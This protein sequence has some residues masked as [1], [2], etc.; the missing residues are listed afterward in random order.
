MLSS[1]GTGLGYQVSL[2]VLASQLALAISTAAE[3]ETSQKRSSMVEEVVVTAQKREQSTV[4][5]PMSI[6]AMGAGELE[7]KGIQDVMDLSFAVPGLMIREEGPGRQSMYMRGIGNNNG[8]G[9]LTSVYLDEAPINTG[10]GALGASNMLNISTADL[11]R[12]EVL[13]GPQGTLYGAGAVSGTVRYI[14][15]DPQLDRFTASGDVALEYTHEGA[16]SQALTMILNTPVVEETLGFRIVGSFDKQGG[17]IDMPD[18]PSSSEDVNNQDISDIRAKMLWLPT[19]ALSIKATAM[20]RRNH[21]DVGTSISD[22][23]YNWYP[24]FDTSKGV[25]YDEASELFNATIT[26][27]FSSIQF[28]TSTTYLNQDSESQYMFKDIGGGATLFDGYEFLSERENNVENITQEFRLVDTADNYTWTLGTYYSDS[29]QGRSSVG[30]VLW[31]GFT[32]IEVTHNEQSSKSWAVFADGSYRFTDGLELGVG[33]RQFSDDRYQENVLSGVN[34]SD[35]FTKTTWRVYGT[36]GVTDNVNMYSSIGTGFRSGG[37]NLEIAG[38]APYGPESLLS[39]ELG[40]KGTLFAGRV[41]YDIAL[42]YSEYQDMLQRSLQVIDNVFRGVTSN[43][44][45][46]EVEGVDFSFDW[47][48]TENLTLSASGSFSNGEIT[49][50]D[51][52]NPTGSIPGDPLDYVPDYSYTLGAEYQFD[53]YGRPSYVRADYNARS[54]ITVIDRTT[55]PGIGKS[56][57]VELLNLRLGTTIDKWRLALYVE[58]ALNENG[59]LDPWGNWGITMRPRPRTIGFSVGVDFE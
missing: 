58:N 26:Y 21:S 45:D 50:A 33:V 38:A 44:G 22:E 42:F 19:D 13:R 54:E 24:G 29:K 5:V 55:M 20:V 30:D 12:V 27:D 17:W 56:D 34:D 36:Y 41:K 2:V 57:S 53:Y 8:S 39:Y 43:I 31:S 11:E 25:P 28:L 47:L 3:A 51:L 49:S 10:S 15:K 46:A 7:S 4:D 48:A 52:S 23:D 40:T 32:Y 37:F 18:S 35:T 9:I 59:S 14:A 1:K 6:T 16:P